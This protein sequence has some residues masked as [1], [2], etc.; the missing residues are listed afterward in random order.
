M[1]R[2]AWRVSTWYHPQWEQ[3]ET[4]HPELVTTKDTKPHERKKRVSPDKIRAERSEQ[5]VA[6]A[7]FP[8]E[9]GFQYPFGTA[10]QAGPWHT[11]TSISIAMCPTVSDERVPPSACPTVLS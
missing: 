11:E 8:P 2:P 6:A 9:P 7:A 4:S 5:E 3:N 10:G 1:C